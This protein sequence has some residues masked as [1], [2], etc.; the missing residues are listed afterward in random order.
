[1]PLYDIRSAK[2][3]KKTP[4]AVIAMICI[5][6]LHDDETQSIVCV[7]R[8]ELRTLRLTAD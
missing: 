4:Y 7:K 2:K 6:Q 3:P 1:M 5:I 8:Q